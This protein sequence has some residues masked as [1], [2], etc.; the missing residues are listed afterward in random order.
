MNVIRKLPKLD[1]TILVSKVK[2]T[3]FKLIACICL[4]FLEVQS[5]AW[6]LYWIARTASF[7][8]CA[9]VVLGS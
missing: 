4:F 3:L 1:T 8:H 6:N 2:L 5:E 9:S 7:Q